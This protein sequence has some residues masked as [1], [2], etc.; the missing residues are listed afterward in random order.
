MEQTRRI[1]KDYRR[2]LRLQRNMSVNTLEAY[3]L[4][5]D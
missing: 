5:V 2:Y 3:S 4:D 1:L